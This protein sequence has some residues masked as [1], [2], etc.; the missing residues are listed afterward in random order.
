MLKVGQKCKLKYDIVEPS[1]MNVQS[2]V[3]GYRGDTVIIDGPVPEHKRCMGDY[4]VF[5][6]YNASDD[7]YLFA[8]SLS[9]IEHEVGIL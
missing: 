4:W 3:H 8:V 7:K 1:R 5:N 6:D 9:E 2:L